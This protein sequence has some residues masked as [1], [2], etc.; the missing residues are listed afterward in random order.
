[1]LLY[2]SLVDDAA[3]AVVLPWLPL[4]Q[5]DVMICGSFVFSTWLPSR[6]SCVLVRFL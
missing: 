5:V 3:Y 4:Y 1:M 2:T 6:T